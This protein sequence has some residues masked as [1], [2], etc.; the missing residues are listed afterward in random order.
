MTICTHAFWLKCMP[1]ER[2][3][4]SRYL[5]QRTMGVVLVDEADALS[6]SHFLATL[7]AGT[8]MVAAWDPA[9]QLQG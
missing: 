8:D 6:P 4:A 5:H 2:A 9:Q 3:T 1:G 7:S